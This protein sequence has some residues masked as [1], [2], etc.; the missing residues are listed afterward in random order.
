MEIISPTSTH[1]QTIISR[2]WNV[3][4]NIPSAP[5]LITPYDK[6]L[7]TPTPDQ[8][9]QGATILHTPKEVNCPNLI[10]NTE[11]ALSPLTEI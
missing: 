6:P 3:R 10:I 11:L 7:I 5:T 4:I 1:E 9:D 2:N 8:I